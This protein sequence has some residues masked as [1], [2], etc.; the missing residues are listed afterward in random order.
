MKTIDLAG[1]QQLRVET[2]SGGQ[3]LTLLGQG[4][5]VELTIC[6][7]NEGAVLRLGQAGLTV[8]TDGDLRFA[9]ENVAIH[10]RSSVELSTD[11]EMRFQAEGD[12]HSLA[13]IQNIEADLGNVNLKANDDVKING[14]RVQLNC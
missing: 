6:V 3:L 1:Q 12:L 14:E 10:G 11:G 7:T 13:R 8:Q 9:A 2:T 5:N 4:G